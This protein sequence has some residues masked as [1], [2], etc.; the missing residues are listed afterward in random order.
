MMLQRKAN[1]CVSEFDQAPREIRLVSGCRPVQ[2][3]TEAFKTL[4]S[5]GIE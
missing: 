3:C 5:K 2:C 4:Y 1:V